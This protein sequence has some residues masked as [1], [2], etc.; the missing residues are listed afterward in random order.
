MATKQSSSA[1]ENKQPIDPAPDADLEDFVLAK[2]GPS[3]KAR[4][5]KPLS[6]T[7][8]TDLEKGPVMPN[9][10]KSTAWALR[11]LNDWR[12]ER[13]K[14]SATGDISPLYLLEKP[15][16]EK[17]NFWLSRFVVEARRKDGEPYPART[18]YLLLAGLLRYGRIPP[19]FFL[20]IK[21]QWSLNTNT[22]NYK[23]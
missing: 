5:T 6:E 12:N 10:E 2:P 17:L 19:N 15:E 13:N 22:I 3:K 18:L 23:V 14:Q 1:K 21:K 8:M 20:A 9:T 11:T 4:F 16:A 7:Q